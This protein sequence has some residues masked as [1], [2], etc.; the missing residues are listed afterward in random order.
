MT[1]ILSGT[2]GLSDVDGSA[3]TPAIRGTDANTGIFFPAA[4][5]IAFAEG[6]VESMRIDSSGNLLAGRTNTTIANNTG[7]I[8]APTFTSIAGNSN[9]TLFLRNCSPTVSA[10]IGGLIRFDAVY[11]NSDGDTTDIAGIAGLRENATNAN[12]AGYLAFSTTP[13][14]G[15]RTER[16]RIDSAGNMG[17]GVTPSAWG[18][19]NSERALQLT[20]GS[21]WSY[22]SFGL[23]LL[24][25][26]FYDSTGAYKYRNNGFAT[27]YFISSA[28]G[29]HAWFTAPSGTAGNTI[30]FTQAMTL[31]ASGNLGIGTTSPSDTVGYG[32][33]LD[34]QSTIGAAVYMRDSTNPTTQ[35]GFIA[36]DGNADVN[37]L[38]IGNGSSAGP[39]RLITNGAER[40][41]I[42]SSGQLLMGTTTSSSNYKLRIS[43]NRGIDLTGWGNSRGEA[44]N[45]TAHDTSN[46]DVMYFNTSA[47]NVGK[48]AITSTAT[49]YVTSS[50]YR[51]KNTVTPMTGA[52]AKVNALK[53][54]TYKWNSDSS[55]GEGFIAHELAEVCPQAVVGEK[56]AVDEDGNPVYQGIDTSFL[57]ATL[58]AAIQELKAIVDAQAVEI[59]ALKGTA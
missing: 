4:D 3:A 25:N 44:I 6:G 31:D 59:A 46:A 36:F 16:L 38:N 28:N 19:A 37:N 42:D 26:A 54:C 41:R 34:I 27:H 48:I 50:D 40:A 13:N 18:T 23:G 8:I 56:D 58:T 7:T 29:A 11:R 20:G 15:S 39:I 10:N 33:A 32:R 5:T 55:D 1:L 30:A 12:Y 9:G 35:Y 43:S 24:N 14:G 51:L 2:D 21:L 47:S 45:L 53:P 17:L 22:S 57:V 52:L 49:S